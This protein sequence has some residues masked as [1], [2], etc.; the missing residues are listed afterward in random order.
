MSGNCIEEIVLVAKKA[1]SQY[2][3]LNI[4]VLCIAQ[5]VGGLMIGTD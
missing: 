3:T 2:T 5:N 1:W 4:R